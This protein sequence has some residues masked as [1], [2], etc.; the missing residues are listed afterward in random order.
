MPAQNGLRLDDHDH[1]PPRRQQA[2][3]G[4][5]LDPI[6]ELQPRALAAAS[7]D[8]DLM[9]EDSVLDDQLPPG[10]DRVHCGAYDLARRLPRGQL[11]HSRPTRATTHVRIREALGNPIPT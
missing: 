1:P 6:H 11:R 9:K 2:G 8:V 4:E 10:A 3:A 7:E 5:Q